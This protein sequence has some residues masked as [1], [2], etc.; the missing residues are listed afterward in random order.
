[1]PEQLP[2]MAGDVG[3]LKPKLERAVADRRL[4]QSTAKNSRT[5]LAGAAT[6]LY[7]NSVN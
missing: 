3:E 7:F 5:L 1:M 2:P 6:D 4:M